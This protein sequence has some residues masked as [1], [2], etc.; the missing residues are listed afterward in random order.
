MQTGEPVEIP[1]RT[2]ETSQTF[3]NPDG[4]LTAKLANEPV[5][6]RRGDN[7]RAV[8]T[9]LEFR[10]D[11][12]VGPKAALSDITLSSGGP[13]LLVKSGTKDGSLQLQSPWTLPRPTLSGSKATYAD[14]MAGVD[15]VT[16]ATTDGFTYNLVV[17]NRE[18]ALNPALKSIHF[19]VV[20]A[21]LSL[22]TNRPAG[23][24]Y[25]AQDGRLVMTAGSAIMWD[26]A[27]PGP[28]AKA[29]QSASSEQLVGEGPRG[30]HVA[31][32]DFKG[33]ASGLTVVPDSALLTGAST[34]YPVVLDPVVSTPTRSAWAAAW[35]LY[36]TTS[37][38]KTT[39][40][41][42]VGYEDYEQHKIV[43]SFFQFSTA[44]YVGKKILGATLRTYE[45]HSASCTARSVTV[46]RT[47]PI[48]AATTWNNQPVAQ[49][50]AGS[51]S[52]AN[53][54]SSSCPDAYVEIPVTNSMVDTAA[55]G[56]STSTFRLSAT[57]ETD[58]IAWKQFD[59]TGE[60]EISYLS[61]PAVP[62]RLGLTDPEVGCG[63]ATAPDTVD[64]A[65][66]QF[67]VTPMLS[68]NDPGN[69]VRAELQIYSSSGNPFI[70]R[71]TALDSQ[72]TPLTLT[73]P[74]SEFPDQVTYHFRAR[75]L[76]P[77]SGGVL[78]SGYTIWCYFKV[79]RLAPPP[80]IVTAKYGSVALANCKTS[81]TTCEEIVP[82]G[83][84]VSYTIKGAVADVLR[85]EYYYQGA[86][87]RSKVNGNTVTVNLVP[88]QNG[89]NTLYVVSFDAAGH[90]S[91]P[92]GFLINLKSA[93]PPVAAW[94]FD[95]GSGGTAADSA[96]P[97]HPLT[98]AGGAAFDDAGRD[99][100][101]IQLDGVDDYAETPTTVVD[102]SQSFTVSA[103]ARVT[104]VKE[105][106]VVGAAG[107]ISSAFELYYSGSL[108]RWV[109]MRVKTD[110][111]SPVNVKALSDEPAVVGAWTLVTGVYDA[112]PAAPKIKLYINGRLQTAG[113]VAYPD[114]AWK[115]T[116][117]LSIGQ[118]QY[119]DIFGNRFAGSL[120]A[121]RIWQRPLNAEAV[122]AEV[123]IRKADRVVA[124]RAARW[125]LDGATLGA[126]QVW[127][128]EDTI[129]GAN[130]AISGFGGST[131]QSAAFVEDDDRGRVLQF[132]GAASEALSLPRA[133]ID[134][135]TSF[136]AAVWVK[137]EDATKP[138]V[139]A[140]QAGPDRDA[141]RL[142]WKPLNALNGQWIFSRTPADT[143]EA[144]VAVFETS[145]DSVTNYWHLIVGTY[146]ASAEDATGS[147]LLGEIGITVNKRA[148]EG[149][150]DGY[151][152]PYRLGS[153]VIG[154]G[155]T[156]GAEVVGQLDDF[157][158]Y[159]GP[160]LDQA[161]CDE[162]PD[163]EGNCPI[164]AG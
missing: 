93:A 80:P 82:F 136:S 64:S 62:R 119:N 32:M 139:I 132:S 74:I 47:A 157:R 95:D 96:T 146:E 28:Q 145:I 97:A 33:D 122:M 41:L 144:S 34:V 31:K 149:G 18:A 135:G 131:D 106:V 48:S 51:K 94:S 89:Y 140:R 90:S 75:T 85:H 4:S 36:P 68:A 53:G 11:G 27:K 70:T 120:D 127:R 26:S 79:D 143:T 88:S 129:Y 25:V 123:E 102:T 164:P 73:I 5:R 103:W 108:N 150:R 42:G 59:S 159:N 58:G 128:T 49:L 104:S 30:A 65:N 161:I 43:R 6:V 60:L 21:G 13:G 9:T 116:G 151:H 91:E 147:G 76:Y 38:Y 115:A 37:F 77:Y 158:L 107:N 160:L 162:F 152:K 10:P 39:H 67:G 109:F 45:T 14:V 130:M 78:A 101:S 110:T 23:P 2:T 52:F 20:S 29:A 22:R 63:T 72:G 154:K 7:W 84:T 61:Q 153:T 133:V 50:L 112:N 99:G 156:A 56:Y 138:A 83:G 86:K 87:V 118:G 111:M 40:S 16:E 3:A 69:R 71:Q 126:D 105:A 124:S 134:G 24:A 117:P 137:L 121:V 54:Y 17:K 44:A 46:T 57:D 12:S 148:L 55:K 1:D 141:W 15:L 163:L 155:R 8:D 35:Q 98:L 114:S 125:P 92:A 100:G 142:E 66:L 81:G 19:P 113:N